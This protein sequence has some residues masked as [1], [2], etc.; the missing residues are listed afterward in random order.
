ML[1]RGPADERLRLEM[2]SSLMVPTAS[3]HSVPLTQIATLEYGFE[4]GIIWQPRSQA[5]P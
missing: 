1:R 5:L 4:E 3:G 2:L